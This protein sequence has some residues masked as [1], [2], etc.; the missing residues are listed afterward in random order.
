MQKHLINE[1]ICIFPFC[2]SLSQSLPLI[3]AIRLEGTSISEL[4]FIFSSARFFSL[5]PLVVNLAKYKSHL[6][7]DNHKTRE[8]IAG[9]C[10]VFFKLNLVSVCVGGEASTWLWI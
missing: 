2:S 3:I 9:F 10:L 5:L 6:H 1:V 8:S 4:L 7:L